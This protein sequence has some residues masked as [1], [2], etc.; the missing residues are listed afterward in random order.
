MANARIA[1]L[2]SE[3][4]AFLVQAKVLEGPPPEWGAST[5][6]H[7]YQ[8]IWPVADDLGAVRASLRFRL[9]K[10]SSEFP[11]LSLVFANNPIYR[12]DIQPNEVCEPNPPWAAK[13]KL[14]PKVCGSHVHRWEDNRQFVLDSG[15]WE[16]PAR[17]PVENSLK[18]VEQMLPWLCDATGISLAPD[19]RNFDIPSKNDL[20]GLI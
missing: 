15:K 20:F 2:V 5:R 9:P 1:T 8:A 16:L 3:A 11:S 7:E 17:R 10:A 12:V 14:P 19:Q 18:R 6:D 13:L 4:D